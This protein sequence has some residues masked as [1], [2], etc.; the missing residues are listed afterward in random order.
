MFYQRIAKRAIF[1][2]AAL[3][4]VAIF[5]TRAHEVDN[6]LT[7]T[8]AA[9]QYLVENDPDFS[10]AQD[11]GGAISDALWDWLRI[12]A[13]REDESTRPVFHF[14]PKLWTF[15]TCSAQQWGLT[16]NNCKFLLV[17]FSN[18][19]TWVDSLAHNG[20]DAGWVDLGYVLHLLEDMTSPAHV[21]NDAHLTVAGVGDIDSF[22]R[23]TL[24]KQI[25]SPQS[26]TI[27]AQGPEQLFNALRNITQNRYFSNDSVFQT[28]CSNGPPCPGPA[29]FNNPSSYTEND[30]YFFG[31]NGKKFA[32]KG[33]RY[34]LSC[35][36]MSSDSH[37]GVCDPQLAGIDSNIAIWQWD[38][39]SPLA[40]SFAAS[41]MK[42]YVVTASPPHPGCRK[43]LRITPLGSGVG[44]VDSA[45][46]GIQ[47][48]PICKASFD[49]GTSVNLVAKEDQ[50][51]VFREWGGSCTGTQGQTTVV[52]DAN[53][54]CSARFE[55]ASTLTITMTGTGTGSVASAPGGIQCNPN[56]HAD[57]EPG[58]SVTLTAPA[59]QDS[60]FKGWSAS[61]T[62]TQGQTTVLMD[63][64]K[65]C[66]AQFD[67]LPKLTVSLIGPG[68]VDSVPA[69]IMCPP[70]CDEIYQIN[71]SVNV[72]A[73]ERWDSSVFVGWSG[74][75]SGKQPQTGV[76]INVSKTCQ[77]KFQPYTILKAHV[78]VDNQFSLYISSNDSVNGEYIGSGTDWQ[79]GY[80]FSKKLVPGVTYYIHIFAWNVDGPGG[81]LGEFSLDNTGFRFANGT[82]TLTTNPTD[83]SLS[84]TSFGVG[85]STPTDEGPN[86]CCVWGE[87][88]G[89]SST[90]HWLW[91]YYS[92]YNPSIW[93]GEFVF[94][95]AAIY[96]N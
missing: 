25:P 45:P 52:M 67:P 89:Y 71:T 27:S 43:I 40:V 74:D 61:C 42:F 55:K 10:C 23:Y 93:Y 95:S 3:L 39:V 8:H 56:C 33:A 18:S 37:N 57:F 58:T 41:L 32:R 1:V 92:N 12:G 30:D 88:G 15:A 28:N 46:A 72:T 35:R 48:N 66:T 29:Q 16:P 68:S 49:T 90:P 19:H 11:N 60:V 5:P 62:G 9:L 26:Y 50:G 87:L 24:G 78:N 65:N 70:D 81:F 2:V 13:E 14:D 17:S 20:S 79:T 96:P 31:I 34:L 77:A 76:I 85:M 22:E 6:H 83:W 36:G 59:D 86:G 47:C 73:H 44:I 38:D 94:F 82:Q 54:N 51:S 69:G 64:N 4:S 7:I 84:T 63:I 75:C 91:N 53:K 21:R 80:S